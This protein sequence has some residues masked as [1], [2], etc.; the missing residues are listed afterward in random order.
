[1][2]SCTARRGC[3]TTSTRRPRRRGRA[4]R[5]PARRARRRCAGR[6]RRAA[7]SRPWCGARRSP[8][9]STTRTLPSAARSDRAERRARR[10][11]FLGVRWRSRGA[12]GRGPRHRRASAAPGSSPGGRGRCPSGATAWRHRRATSARV[13]VLWVPARAAAS[14][15]VTTWCMTG[16]VRLDAEQ[17][18]GHVDGARIGAG[19]R[20]HVELHAAPP[21]AAALTGLHRVADEHEAAL[22][23]GDGALDRSRPRSASASTTSRLRVV[24]CSSPIG[25]PSSC[26]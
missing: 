14:W 11:I 25:R 13:L 3:G 18:V 4:R 23:A 17:L 10:I 5:G 20:L 19:G 26:P 6:A 8:S 7:R 1:M 21:G 15:A 9:S 12:S 24:T 22:G 2:T 16:D